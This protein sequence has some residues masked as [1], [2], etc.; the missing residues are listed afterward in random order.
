M[1]PTHLPKTYP[2]LEGF[3]NYSPLTVAPD[4]SVVDAIA[5]LNKVENI[6]HSSAEA[7][8]SQESASCV[9]VVNNSHL[10]GI[11]TESD[12]ARL[13]AYGDNLAG[14]KMAEVMTQPVVTLKQ[15]QAENA[16]TALSLMRQHQIHHLPIVDEQEQLL[17]TVTKT[18]LLS[19][20]NPVAMVESLQA[21]QQK[22]QAQIAS[23]ME[24]N[25]YQSTALPSGEAP[26]QV[27][28][29]VQ[30]NQELQQ[31]LTQLVVI[32]E[33]LLH[34]NEEL[35]ATSKQ[36]EEKI[37][38]Q[39]N[40]LSQVSDAV[41]AHDNEYRITYWNQ[42]AE[43]LYG[44]KADDIIGRQREAAFECRWVNPEDEQAARNALAAEASWQGENIVIKK[45]GEEIYVESSVSVLRDEAG[46]SIGFL[47][48]VRDITERKHLEL[49]LQTSQTNLND[50]LQG[51]IASI[52]CFQLFPNGDWEYK[53]QSPGCEALFGY[54]A[55]EIITNKTLWL[56]RVLPED[57]ENVIMPLIENLLADTTVTVEY[58][59]YHKDGELRWISSTY[60]SRRDEVAD[61]WIVTGVS[62]DI[63]EQ[64]RTESALREQESKLRAIGDNLPNGAIYQVSRELNENI[65]FHY[66]S[67]G[68]ERISGYKP[69]EILQDADLICN[70]FI[71]A[72]RLRLVEA[73][74]NSIR[75]LS[76]L[77][78]QLQKRNRNGEIRWV[79]LRAAPR[80]LADE[81]IIWDGVM[82]D[83]TDLKQA[84]SA[85]LS[86][87]ERSRTLAQKL[88]LIT[89]NA[90][91]YIFELDCDGR[92]LF[93]N[94][95]YEGVTQEQ[96]IGTLLTDWF[97]EAQHSEITSVLERVFSS[98]Q[99]QEIEYAVPNP[100]GEVR[101]YVTQI[102]PIMVDGT[103]QS[104]VLTATDVTEGTQ[105]EAALRQS[106]ERF[107]SLSASSPIG[108][109][110]TDVHG[111]CLYTNPRWQEMTG[112]TLE[113]SL[114]NGWVK[115][116]HP[117]DM[118]GVFTAWETSM[119]EGHNF[120][121][122]FR[123]L[124]SQGKVRWVHSRAAAIHSATGEIVGYVGTDEDITERKQSEQKIHEQAALLD[125]ATDAI[126]LRGLDNTILYWNKSAERIY[127]WRA[128]EA[129]GQNANELI[130][131]EIY[132]ELEAA[133]HTVTEYGS[134]QGEL[135]KL[136][137]QGR[138]I[139]VASRLTLV[140]DDLGEPKYILT[141]D[142]D[143]TDKKQ[144]EAQFLRAQR[145]ESLGTLAS[146]IAHDLNNILTPILVISQLL[147]L[148]FTNVDERS[149]E[150]LKL[151]ESNAKRG[152]DLVK[153]ILSFVRG[154]EGKRTILQLKHL[155]A[156]VAQICQQTFP[157]SIEIRRD[158]PPDLW[159]VAADPT[160]L[161]Q[162]FM[163]LGVN[164]RDAMP[165]GG[166]LTISGS[167][168]FIDA[169]YAKMHF[170]AEVGS[171]VVI[172]IG[173]TGVGI[174]AAIMERIFD[175]FFTTKEVGKGTG[176]GLSTVL[177]IVKNHGGFVDVSSKIGK[178]TQFHVYLPSSDRNASLQAE[179]GEQPF[180]N[181]ELILLVEDEDEI[182]LITKT[183]LETHKYR[184]LVAKDGIEAIA[185]YAQYQDEISIVLM[186][187]MMPSMD[188]ATAIRTLQRMKPRVQII[189]MSGLASTEAMAHAAG[190]GVQGFV[191]KPFTARELIKTIREVL[192][193]Q[194]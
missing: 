99:V 163:N 28:E 126:F 70:Q 51:A 66:I 7:P 15:S 62:I 21:L 54:T 146:G 137:K 105:A 181:D 80:R 120:S 167:N 25:Q 68:I 49:A 23:L 112:L 123:F 4:T 86:T 127:G 30:A 106:E 136:T 108:I 48:V 189:A 69:E 188:G 143:I 65:K 186:D 101:Y 27:T 133:L 164:A 116:I 24:V 177:G 173:D 31:S 191:S 6:Y 33:E 8:S 85:L 157:K 138:E 172:T 82:I 76:I 169:S 98:G 134:W 119:R 150:M 141:V 56:S 110:E 1:K 117:E 192:M 96:V 16:L 45:N 155:I 149:Q 91:A 104:A 152:A 22:L 176:L 124:T 165:E 148:K 81:R 67:A 175:P 184:V 113:E 57:R 78:I 55:E 50:I 17:G 178:G 102:A 41:I 182:A 125:V 135:H 153:Q 84:E 93:A 26:E 107:R 129:L 2:A 158:I 43:R 185:L 88:H 13:T 95:T 121:R 87:E 32:Q 60:T 94:R 139:F 64:K 168:L 161:H 75:N 35:A 154:S 109:F 92:I 115:A 183:T 39:A 103:P 18:S 19:A 61:C 58:R 140:R 34:Q 89:S 156:D 12:I 160:Q 53:Y 47:A 42:G 131:Q 179:V 5:L 9:I 190:T 73:K 111:N 97:P 132:P 118:L 128:E 174:P 166:T 194:H 3:L 52:V 180:G 36:A 100:Q 14:V 142:T 46:A 114:G 122:E 144:L 147:P 171:Y 10:V 130:Y 59:F 90:L 79:H 20:L 40:I 77:D 159:T 162:V 74:E 71:E 83:I 29:L 38:F 193:S 11:F 151:L 44:I 145:L 63:T 170:E 187:M 72:D 37:Q